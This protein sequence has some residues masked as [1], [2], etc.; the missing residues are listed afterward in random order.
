[1]PLDIKK[2]GEYELFQTTKQNEI[3][4]LNGEDWFSIVQ[5]QGGEIIVLTDSDHE[6]DR[7]LA[8]GRFFFIEFEDDPEFRDI[9]HLFLEDEGS[10]REVVVPQGLP[11]G[12]DKQKKVVRTDD[13]ID[14]GELEDYLE[15]PR[16]AGPGAARAGRPGGG[17]MANVAHH[18]RG[19]DLPA[20]RGDLIQHA[21]KKK[22]PKAV[23]DQLEELPDRSFKSIADVTKSIGEAKEPLPV[24]DYDDLS[25][26]QI[27]ARLEG[28]DRDELKR[29]RDHEASGLARK[30]ILQQIDEKIELT[31]EALPIDGYED[32]PADEI[33]GEL[34]RLD[35]VELREIR[36]FEE[37]HDA[38]KSVLQAIDRKL[39][40]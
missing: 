19:M 26:E 11:T 15:N 28:L 30:T 25:A 1:M 36:K 14:A 21:R 10:Y 18:L 32:M 6:K 37:K 9:P 24:E 39:Q 7:T 29:L 40:D 23:L 4:V 5:G 38:R 34:D 20:G 3:L 2:Q 35:D 16:P 12:G 13:T 17:S 8:R 22:A 31:E 27:P 33:V